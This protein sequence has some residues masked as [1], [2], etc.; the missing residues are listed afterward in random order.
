MVGKR[1][2]LVSKARVKPQSPSPKRAALMA[3]ALAAALLQ[4]CVSMERPSIDAATIATAQP[5]G[6]GAGARSYADQPLARAAPIKDDDYSLL[7]LSGGGPDGAYG[8]GLL[9]GWSEAGTRPRFAVVTGVSTGALIA[10]LAFA[11]PAYDDRLAQLYTG[12]HL[13]TLLRGGP[14]ISR[15]LRGP[16]LYSNKRLAALIASAVDAQLLAAVA[17]EYRAGRRLY[18]VTANMDAERLAVWDMGAIAASDDPGAPDLFRSILL[19]AASIPVALP[20]VPIAA[21]SGGQPVTEMHADATLFRLFYFDA[22]L[23]PGT[24]QRRCGEAG[25]RCSLYVIAHNKLVAEPRTLKLS[26]ASVL[27]RSVATLVKAGAGQSLR[28]AREVADGAAARFHLAYL[29]T[30]A[31]AVSPINFDR[32]YMAGLYALGRTRAAQGRA[33]RS[34]LPPES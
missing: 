33:W 20:P 15:I 19:A 2:A 25:R 31:A 1:D 32:D 14:G 13:S 5:V 12:D 23:L 3:A 17:A 16:N 4:G 22:T 11:G 29:E 27:T 18:V 6:P 8:A 10:P 30:D 7:A 9:K 21:A 34:D 28:L 24:G 26:A